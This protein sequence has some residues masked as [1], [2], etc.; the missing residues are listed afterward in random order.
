[1]A[2]TAPT[3][4]QV[5]A[6]AAAVEGWLS[7]A[8]GRALYAAARAVAGRGAI[9]EIGS[10]KGRSTI[11]LAAGAK[12]AGQRVF[13]ID[14]HTHS[15]EDPHAR[16]LA[17]FQ[18]NLR[19]AGLA[20]VVEPLVMTSTDAAAILKGP[21]ELLFVDGDHS[22]EGAARD[23]FIWLPRVVDGGTVMFHDVA[24]AAYSGPRRVFRGRVCLSSRFESIRRVGSMTAARKT[25]RRR[26][27]AALWGMTAWV[28]LF[29]YDAKAMAGRMKRAI[30]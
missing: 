11:W 21:V 6:L 9:V 5:A 24:T 10:W 12:V 7:D 30:G 19:R 3:A 15:K 26:G 4:D 18:E 23:A 14:P 2:D 8:Q 20:D 25:A 13:A 22:Y 17:E 28:L 29:I 27:L 1:M 16:T